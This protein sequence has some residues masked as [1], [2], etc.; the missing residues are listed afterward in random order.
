M[1]MIFAGSRILFNSLRSSN[2]DCVLLSV[3]IKND[4]EMIAAAPK[5][6]TIGTVTE[7]D[8][9]TVCTNCNATRNEIIVID[10]VIAPVISTVDLL[11]LLLSYSAVTLLSESS[12]SLLT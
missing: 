4:R 1:F 9:L 11:L 2:G 8:A 6:I 10:S 3:I 12:M 7:S 5:P